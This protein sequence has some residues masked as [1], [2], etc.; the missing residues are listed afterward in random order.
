MGSNEEN[1]TLVFH[2][3][4]WCFQLFVAENGTK[5]KEDITKGKN[6]MWLTLFFRKGGEKNHSKYYKYISEVFSGGKN[7]VVAGTSLTCFSIEDSWVSMAVT[8]R[9]DI[10]YFVF[11]KKHCPLEQL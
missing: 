2:D 8:R 10:L 4:N 7:P 3:Y 9:E 1:P 5:G 11:K 6:E